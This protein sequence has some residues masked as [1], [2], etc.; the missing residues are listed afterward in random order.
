MR[1]AFKTD[2]LQGVAVLFCSP[3]F[4]K[5][6]SKRVNPVLLSGVGDQHGECILLFKEI[7][8]IKRETAERVIQLYLCGYC[9]RPVFPIHTILIL[10][11]GV[12]IRRQI[13]IQD[14]CF[15]VL[16]RDAQVAH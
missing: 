3:H 12:G 8:I 2:I 13:K 4:P 6:Y 15:F 7:P 1:S 10:R 14:A 16:S 9:V 5:K 11:H